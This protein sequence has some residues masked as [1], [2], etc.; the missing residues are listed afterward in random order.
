MGAFLDAYLPKYR[1]GRTSLRQLLLR[2]C[3]KLADEEELVRQTFSSNRPWAIDGDHVERRFNKEQSSKGQLLRKSP[4]VY[5]LH[6]DEHS[7][8]GV[9]ECKYGIKAS[10][11]VERDP[12]SKVCGKVRETVEKFNTARDFLK[13]EGR[14]H[15]GPD[16]VV[17]SEEVAQI[18]L[19]QWDSYLAELDLPPE[20]PENQIRVVDTPSLREELVALGVDCPAP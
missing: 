2:A 9:I 10:P 7:A 18:L 3:E 5:L 16:F 19:F 11:A 6:S 12:G 13:A 17:M 15:F 1:T 4:D 20:A 8:F 14:E